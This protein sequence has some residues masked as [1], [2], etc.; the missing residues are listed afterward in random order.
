M[1][2]SRR[3]PISGAFAS[4]WAALYFAFQLSAWASHPRNSQTAT[5]TFDPGI[6]ELVSS[7]T[8]PLKDAHTRRVVVLDLR[9]PNGQVHPAGKWLADQF[10]SALKN[11]IP[12]IE[13][14]DRSKI[15][16]ADPDADK[17]PD[18]K[19]VLSKEVGQALSV[20]ADTFIAGSFARISESQ[21]GIS[22]SVIELRELEKTHEMRTG[23]V[24]ISKE[25][26]DISQ[27]TAIPELVVKDGIPLAGSGGISL[28]ICTHCP[29][30]EPP[31][32]PWKPGVVQLSVVVTVEG[33]PGKIEVVE[34]PSPELA[35]SAV[36]AVQH[37]RFKPAIGFD[38]KPI[39]VVS[40]IQCS[41][42]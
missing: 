32:G 8:V 11:E 23:I 36:R 34:S 22:L 20:G 31:K 35:A 7:L 41:F 4:I 18:R 25:L 17:T 6:T 3:R 16:S 13:V 5:N 24:S 30:P 39:R 2:P 14:V 9:G 26:T 21:I 40:L 10:S 19:V 28:P 37:W 12:D 1:F 15:A 33:R 38:A 27:G 42:N 29:A